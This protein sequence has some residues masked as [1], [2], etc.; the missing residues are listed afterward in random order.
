M[1]GGDYLPG[2][3]HKINCSKLVL[4]AEGVAPA[5]ETSIATSWGARKTPPWE[6]AP[7]RAG[8]EAGAGRDQAPEDGQR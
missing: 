3:G 2:T 8:R 7:L 6:E 1:E 4:P 5:K